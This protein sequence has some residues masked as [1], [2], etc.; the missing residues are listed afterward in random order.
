MSTRLFITAAICLQATIAYS[1]DHLDAPALDGLGQVDVNDLYAFQ[2]P[3]DPANTVLI[4]TTN[5][6]AGV[7][8]PTDFGTDVDYE[9]VIDNDGDAEADITYRTTFAGTGANQ[10]LSLTRG[11]V[12]LGSGSVEQTLDVV[13][14]GRIY[15]GVFDDPFFFDLVGFNDS[16][17][18]TGEDTLAGANVSAIVLEVPST[19]LH[20]LEN[21]NIGVW[22]R[23]VQ[24]GNQVDRIGRP[25]INTALLAS[26]R[27]DAF[28][29][30]SPATDFAMFGTEVNGAI[31]G[32][33]N[34]ANADALTPILLPDILTFDTANAD[35]F[36]NGR[37]LAD[38]VIDAELTLLTASETP[39][40]DGVDMNDV[41][42]QNSFPYLGEAHVVPE[43]SGGMIA[44]LGAGG[45]L[46]G[47]RRRRN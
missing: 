1:A 35:G 47:F 27:K 24:D 30:G 32:L 10:T 26:D 18:F 2:S 42:F 31:A 23:T 39:I 3:S 13:G 21:T 8:S 6:F 36:L 38:D 28:N 44:L 25:A 16:F 4:L 5:P 45:L 12:A 14:G 17:N 20:T 19:E 9:F 29:A 40:G 34:E 22:A 33:S 37:Q 7:A 46:L 11:E 43:P 15:A 41:A